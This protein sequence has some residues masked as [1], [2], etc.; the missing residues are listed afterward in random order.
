[1]LKSAEIEQLQEIADQ[2]YDDKQEAYKCMSLL[3]ERRR[4][5]KQQLTARW[6]QMIAARDAADCAYARHQAKWVAFHAQ[7]DAISAQIAQ[8]IE[9]AN[10]AK[11]NARQAL[12]RSREARN[13]GDKAGAVQYTSQCKSYNRTYAVHMAEKDRLTGVA[14]TATLPVSDLCEF[15]E[16]YEEAMR[17]HDEAKA[18]YS[19]VKA[20]HERARAEFDCL[21]DVWKKANDASYKA[22]GAQRAKWST[23]K[24]RECGGDLAINSDWKHPPTYCN[25]CKDHFRQRK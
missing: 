22:V 17:R 20:E 23:V 25:A 12:K 10:I 19:E 11:D 7:A 18:S 21:N 14:E 6:N 13:C 16:A 15:N 1:M 9:C 4:E 8:A 3:G 24:C 2:A 5:S